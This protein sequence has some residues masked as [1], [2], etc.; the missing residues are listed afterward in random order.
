MSD[1]QVLATLAELVDQV[2]LTS[3][4]TAVDDRFTAGDVNV[5]GL[6]ADI[7]TRMQVSDQNLEA[8]MQVSDQ[9][10]QTVSAGMHRFAQMVAPNP[11]MVAPSPTPPPGLASASAT[12]AA[13]PVD[14]TPD[15]W[16]GRIP[17]APSAPNQGHWRQLP[18]PMHDALKAKDF[19]AI[20]PFDGDLA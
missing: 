5:R 19:I 17:G 13:I 8:R 12:A 3:K 7:E 9:N 10:L 15:P 1:Q 16:W 6:L 18:V 4:V 11:Q 20:T 2:K 14:S